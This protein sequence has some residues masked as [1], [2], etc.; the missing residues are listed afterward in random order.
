MDPRPESLTTEK[1]ADLMYIHCIIKDKDVVDA[2]GTIDG[3]K[4]V[5]SDSTFDTAVPWSAREIKE[6]PDLIFCEEYAVNSRLDIT[7]GK[8]N[9]EKIV[10]Q[11]LKEIRINLPESRVVI[12]L[13]KNRLY[14]KQF[15]KHLV[16][17][18]IYDLHFVE[19]FDLD[20]LK[21]FIFAK[22]KNIKDT[23]R[24][25]EAIKIDPSDEQEIETEFKHEP[26]QQCGEEGENKKQ[27]PVHL[28]RKTKFGL[29]NLQRCLCKAKDTIT[30]SLYTFVTEE[31]E[32]TEEANYPKE[33]VLEEINKKT[34]IES[35][36]EPIE[37]VITTI[38]KKKEELIT[39][40]KFVDRTN[41]YSTK[42]YVVVGTAHRVGTT[43]FS[44]AL[45]EM[46]NEKHPVEILD[47]GGGAS[48]WLFHG[49]YSVQVRKAPPLSISPG[50]ITIVDSG[51]RIPHEIIPMTEAVF[52][53]TDLSKNAI[54]L[55]PY[56]K[57]RGYLVGNRG[58]KMRGLKE[59]ADLW[60]IDVFCT[61]PEDN[62]VKQAEIKGAI[63][64]PSTW[65]RPIKNGLRDIEKG[66]N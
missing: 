28:L 9:R 7:T 22:P 51:L 38:E 66:S 48:K 36:I 43:S 8:F 53:V 62:K 17:L 31:V 63:P 29:D 26:D 11:A 40:P 30:H 16:T 13:Q 57:L 19:T 23:A 64:L 27:K 3:I 10:L 21:K 35:V 54:Y 56:E 45:A 41:I 39:P 44:L 37:T 20:D 32:E 49:N 58:A 60:G 25:L 61:L 1:G 18:G 14:Q 33:T 2:I 59:L 42:V 24:Y 50:I 46:L 15:I 65:K 52:V 34:L 5:T 55:K 6:S 47:S 4:K 12:L